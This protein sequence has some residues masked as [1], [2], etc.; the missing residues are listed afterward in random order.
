MMMTTMTTT[1]MMMILIMITEESECI[2]TR[3]RF[4]IIIIMRRNLDSPDSG[5]GILIAAPDY[6]QNRVVGCYLDYNDL[7]VLDPSLFVAVDCFFLCGGNI[8]IQAT[9]KGVIQGLSIQDNEF[10]LCNNDTIIFDERHYSFN[11][12]Q[13]VCNPFSSSQ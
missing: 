9:Q 4:L 12:V 6:T 11:T 7:V 2:S 13:D 8:V 3:A 5:I 10:A 1:M